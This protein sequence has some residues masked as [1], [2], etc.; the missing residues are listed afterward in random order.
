MNKVLSDTILFKHIKA[1]EP[2][3]LTILFDKYYQQLCRFAFVFI[4]KNEI[5]E[6]LTANVFINLWDNRH[7][8]DIRT[9]LKSY[10]YRS[11]KNQVISYLRKENKEISFCDFDFFNE[12]CKSPE[13]LFI[14]NEMDYEFDKAFLKI[15]P[16]AKLAFKLHRFD[17]LKYKEIA[18]I[19][20]ISVSAVEK[21]I[22]TALKLLLV[23][24]EKI[25]Q[26][27]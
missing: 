17:G 21:N 24:L 12:E 2:K 6:E 9:S 11:A 22:A 7:K 19:M 25:I 8:I 5:V 26:S 13:A 10:L 27:V 23:E 15:P 16:R 14:E 3:A 4:P 18:E 1:G 20:E